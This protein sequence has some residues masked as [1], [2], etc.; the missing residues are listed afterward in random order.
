[1]RDHGSSS[2]ATAGTVADL[3]SKL[4]R[5][6]LVL[7][8]LPPALYFRELIRRSGNDPAVIPAAASDLLPIADSEPARAND[9]S[10]LGE[11][12]NSCD[13]VGDVRRGIPQYHR[14]A[15][16]EVRK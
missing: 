11:A 5:A 9:D 16:L 2:G 12:V 13:S 14:I 7:L 10:R 6:F 3:N 4:I 8:D 15:W 1:M